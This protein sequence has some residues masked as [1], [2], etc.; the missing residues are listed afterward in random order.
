MVMACGMVMIGVCECRDLVFR[1][2]YSTKTSI[3]TKYPEIHTGSREARLKH[4]LRDG[5]ASRTMSG[6]SA[7][8]EVCSCDLLVLVIISMGF[9]KGV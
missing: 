3:T 6:S 8:W 4:Y 1:L 7:L 5:T 9:I 2:T